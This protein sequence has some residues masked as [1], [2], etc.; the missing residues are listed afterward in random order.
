MPL[1]SLLTWEASCR[2]ASAGSM[3]ANHHHPRIETDHSVILVGS[4][5]AG[6]FSCSRTHSAPVGAGRKASA[7]YPLPPTMARPATSPGQPP[8]K[9]Q[10]RGWGISVRE[11]SGYDRDSGSVAGRRAAAANPSQQSLAGRAAAYGATRGGQRVRP[12]PAPVGR[13]GSPR[14]PAIALA[15]CRR[16]RRR[17]ALRSCSSRRSTRCRVGL[18]LHPT[19]LT[20]RFARGPGSP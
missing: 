10:S 3:Q 5:L 7:A 12:P 1:P 19:Y 9:S 18:T 13:R 6:D 20:C 16:P 11:N 2:H 14:L 15:A 4:P 8:E 17:P